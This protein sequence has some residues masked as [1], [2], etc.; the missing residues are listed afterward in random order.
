MNEEQETSDLEWEV[1]VWLR[2]HPEF[3]TRHP[4]LA[5]SLRVPHPCRPA[6]SL[7]EYQNRLLRERCQRLHD[8]LVDLVAI[9]RDNDRLAERVQRLALSLL[10]APGEPDELLRG[11]KAILRDEFSA[12]RAILCMAGLPAT[13]SKIAAEF[14]CPDVAALFE[15]LFQVGQPHCGRLRPEQALVLFGDS[16]PRVAS[17]ALIPLGGG[18]WRGLLGLGSWDED[19]FY[20]GVGTLFLGRIGELISQALQARL[21]TCQWRAVSDSPSVRGR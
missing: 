2:E 3:F 21:V 10:D 6:V 18:E 7:L 9:A 16:A 8:K 1:A 11:V 17:A 13:R 20:P 4:E 12:D 14:L 15:D 5:E 19:R